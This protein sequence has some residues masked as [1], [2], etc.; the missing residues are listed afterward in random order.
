MTAKSRR[1][2][3]GLLRQRVRR[4]LARLAVGLF[5]ATERRRAAKWRADVV[6]R[7]VD[8][9][10]EA[11]ADPRPLLV[12]APHPDDETIGCAVLMA[13]RR[14]AG[15]PVV[16]VVVSDGETSHRSLTLEPSEL[17]RLRRQESMSACGLLGV[18]D[19]R[20]L[21][22][23]ERDLREVDER[24][25]LALATLIIQTDPGWVAIP[26][27]CDWHPEHVVVHDAASSAL[28]RAAFAGTA[29]E[30]PVWAWADGAASARPMAMPWTRLAALMGSRKVGRSTP[31]AHLVRT[32]DY[33]AR[34][35]AAFARYLTQ[36]TNY[37]G[38]ATWQ[39]FPAGWID[40]F[41][42][43]P[44]VYFPHQTQGSTDVRR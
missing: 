40:T 39:P 15:R 27:R 5:G 14:D 36:V 9:T 38:E 8:I 17:G 32:G 35:R 2:V 20:F 29:H 22:F 12:I 23:G 41:V 31:Q 33:A 37:T 44:E 4:F 18:L 43:G 42:D 16:V 19:V 21:G 24:L 26:Y 6:A 1:L 7:G 11:V 34:K 28:R 3:L 10:A 30:Y 13:R 25:V